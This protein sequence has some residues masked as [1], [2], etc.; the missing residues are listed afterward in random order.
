[1]TDWRT[2]RVSPERTHHR[3][4]S[5]EEA[6]QERFD[7]VLP[8]HAPGLAPARRGSTAWHIR[9]DGRP[10]YERRFRKTFGFYEG[11]AAAEAEDGWCHI[12]PDG[13]PVYAERY[14][15]CG[16]VQS[17]R[18][19]VRLRDGRYL[20]LTDAGVRSGSSSWRYAGDFREG[21]AV[22]QRDDGLHTH[23]D[24]SGAVLHDRWFVDLDVFHKGFARARDSAGWMHVN[25]RGDAVY[26]RRFAAVEPFYNGQARVERLDGG[27]ELID[28]Q[29]HALLE[30]RPSLR[31]EFAELSRDLVGFWRTQAICA[32]VELGII[33]AL[34]AQA[35]DIAARCRLDGPR[36]SRLLRGLAELG[37][38]QDEGGACSLTARGAYLR[39]DHPLTLADAA[40]EYG[41][42]FGA[43]WAGLPALLRAD[44]PPESVDFFG[45]V[46]KDPT[47]APGHHRMLRSYARHDYEGV[48]A[49]LG[50]NGHET[51]IDG[52]GGL[53]VLAELL[54]RRHPGVH[55]LLLERP[56]VI[57]FIS[58][59]ADVAERI[60]LREAD[61]FSPWRVTGDAVI[62]S[63]VLH[64]W[65][66]GDASRILR[67]ARAVLSPGGRLFAIEMLLPE[68]GTAGG[69]CDLHLLAV[70]GGKERTAS[71]FSRLLEDNGFRFK[72]IRRLPALPS[73]IV[74]EAV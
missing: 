72:E 10:A 62:L 31:S 7:A 4:D 34:P 26:E 42:H 2:L 27:I 24:M 49:T 3:R 66:D 25:E 23:V 51:V 55:V 17:G 13:E 70:T 44:G 38:V 14:A 65:E 64:D 63:R 47:R 18:V 12:A 33:E 40:L 32:A 22:V 1:M 39:R 36:T 59:P 68:A 20:H 74:G 46:A 41:R 35:G 11:R 9:P 73:V 37:L 52:G 8:F 71:Q 43:Q 57:R 30:L 21:A 6:Y 19:P 29:G 48:P 67:N 61:L 16:N 56:E 53:G 28:E 54:S 60:M 45:Q 58:V 15:W 50:L 5:G 69:L